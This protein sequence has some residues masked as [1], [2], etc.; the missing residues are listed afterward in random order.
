MVI[1]LEDDEYQQHFYNWFGTKHQIDYKITT[2]FKQTDELLSQNPGSILICDIHLL[3]E[4]LSGVEMA[5]IWKNKYDCIIIVVT[6]YSKDYPEIVD[7]TGDDSWYDL[8]ISKPLM[9]VDWFYSI[10]TSFFRDLVPYNTPH[11]V[12]YVHSP[13]VLTSVI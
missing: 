2:T 5:K 10:L 11:V 13:K 8:Y 1:F 7:R 4:E 12:T 9:D 3:G 6:A